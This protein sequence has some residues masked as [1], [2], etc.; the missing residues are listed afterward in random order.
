MISKGKRARVESFI[1]VVA[2]LGPILQIYGWGKY[3]FAFILYPLLALY[4]F[5]RY[6]IEY[7]M[8]AILGAYF[9][10]WIFIHVIGATSFASAIPLGTIRNVIMF[11]LLFVAIREDNIERLFRYY[12]TIAIVCIIFF[13][14][15][16]LGY[17]A[18]ETRISG[19]FEFLPLALDVDDA[20]TYYQS[21]VTRNRS[22]SFFS[23]PAEFAQFLLPLLA[24]ELLMSKKKNRLL[25]SFF[26]IA[27]LLFLRSG[28]ALFGLSGVAIVYFFYLLKKRNKNKL[29]WIVVSITLV[30][31]VGYYYVTSEMGQN[32]M[33]R[34]DQL[35]YT[36]DAESGQS[37]FTRMW[38]GYYVYGEFSTI[39]KI[40]GV[41]DVSRIKSYIKQSPVSFAFED[42]DDMYFNT[43]QTFL[44]HTGIIGVIMYLI[45]L[46][47]LF[48]NNSSCGK[49]IILTLFIL[50]FISSMYFS[51]SFA[52]YIVIAA[53]LQR[54]ERLM[55]CNKLS[56]PGA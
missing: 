43:M 56:L 16:E 2:L 22:A 40:I 24:Y 3:D 45:F 21:V 46:Y 31:I 10:Y 41:D 11:L 4:Y 49:A 47:S 20:A 6:G 19:V 50:S 9:V 12:S 7:K 53:V 55:V 48:K 8:P 15:Q 35:S 14:I 51:E 18:T 17:A 29:L 28:N 26:I 13:F 52:L 23:E 27:T 54:L 39:E 5:S 38:R 25:F 44:V 33:T 42:D 1:I 37:G 30:S 32:L 34:Q 36:G